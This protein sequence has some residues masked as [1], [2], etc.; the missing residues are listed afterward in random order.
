VPQR[1]SEPDPGF[2]GVGSVGKEGLEHPDG[3]RVLTALR[4]DLSQAVERVRIARLN[5]ENLR[6]PGS[7][8]ACRP[9]RW[10]SFERLSANDRLLASQSSAE[11]FLVLRGHKERLDPMLLDAE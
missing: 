10:C 2:V 1:P 9:A 11:I 5:I 8:L 6:K 4:D 7:A 3:C